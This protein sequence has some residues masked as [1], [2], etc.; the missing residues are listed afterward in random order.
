MITLKRWVFNTTHHYSQRRAKMKT[1]EKKLGLVFVIGIFLAVS[2]L[3]LAAEQVDP[4]REIGATPGYGT[5]VEFYEVPEGFPKFEERTRFIGNIR[6]TW[7]EMGLQYGK[8]A[9][10]LIRFATDCEW[11][12]KVKKFGREHLKEDLAR[13]AKA[14]DEYSPK[15]TE[16]LKGI[17]EGASDE[18]AKSQYKGQVTDFERI[19]L[20]N[21]F[22]SFNWMHPKPE[23]HKGKMTPIPKKTS[24][25]I[26]KKKGIGCTGMALSGKSRGRLS[27]PTK[28][29]ETIITQNMDI[30]EYWPWGWNV[31]YV[32]TPSDPDANVFWSISTAGMAGGNNMIVNEKGLA[33]ALYYGGGSDDP[34]DFGIH[35]QPLYVYAIAYADNVGEA[36]EL[37]TLGPPEYRA[38]T[39]R[40][41]VIHSGN[42]AYT[43]ADP[44]KVAQVE[45]TAHRYTVRY[46]GD[47][48]EAGNYLVYANF[49]GSNHYF[50][51]NNNRVDKPIG[52][53]APFGKQ[54]Y[55]TFDWHI[56]HHLGE[57]DADM[58][59]R[60]QGIRFWYDKETGKKIE[61]LAD[62]VTP[63][64]QT[65]HTP[66]AYGCGG[67]MGVDIGGTMWGSQAILRKN[68]KTEI[69][70]TKGRPCEWLGPWDRTDFS[71]YG[72]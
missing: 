9:G 20:I 10:D 39:G 32:A 47:M 42:W 61:F 68:G 7:N 71:G 31:A 52:T 33:F 69:F 44:D 46:P 4:Y 17:A 28:N 29:G 12:D 40:K 35:W 65:Q 72:K 27:S 55:Y 13:Y 56:R 14:I 5:R 34:Y 16:F 53:V 43:V 67:I 1:L 45:V 8:R 38:R 64:W 6:G 36:I 60:M 63:L 41:I 15:M 57:I 22:A 30:G 11:G 2:S 25:L 62:G 59:K 49:Y 66:C 54:R 18:F 37:L 51:E 23:F 19:I 50:D 21:V 24:M 48:N 3:A 70:W 58:A 26:K